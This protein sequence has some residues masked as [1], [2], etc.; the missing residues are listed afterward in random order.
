MSILVLQSS[1][2]RRESWLLC[3]V[4][5]LLSRDGFVVLPRGAMGLSAVCDCKIS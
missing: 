4:V 1:L 2:W 3:L 5:F